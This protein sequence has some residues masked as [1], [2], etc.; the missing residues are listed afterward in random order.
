MTGDSQNHGIAIVAVSE[1]EAGEQTRLLS[2]YAARVYADAFPD[3]DLRENPVEWQ[4]LLSGEVAAPM[5]WTEVL[6]LLDGD[7]VAGGATVELYRGA[8]CGLLTYIAIHPDYRGRGLARRLVDR[9]HAVV[10]RRGGAGTPLFAETEHYDEAHDDAERAEIV[11]RQ[12][13]LAALGALA[14]EFD[15][16]MPPLREGAAPRRLHLLLLDPP[17]A[18]RRPHVPARTV[19]ALL[20]ELACSL[21]TT[22][23]T[24][25]PTRAMR[26]TLEAAS[27]L[28]QAPLP[29]TRFDARYRET[30]AFPS[31]AG[32][33][34]SFAFELG[35]A[36]ERGTTAPSAIVLR[37]IC[38]DLAQD[39]AVQEALVEPTRS[40]L[41]DVTT[42][43]PGHNGRPMLFLASAA[44]A[45]SPDRQVAMMRDSAWRYRY[46][47]ETRELATI[48]RRLDLRLHDSF[49]VFE[50]G[51]AFYI[52]SL[53]V[54]PASGQDLDEYAV[55]QLQSLAILPD[56]EDCARDSG[57]PVFAWTASDGED[58]TGSLFELA[59]ARVAALERISEDNP[60][61]DAIRDLLDRYHIRPP[62]HRRLRIDRA[63]LRNLCVSIE[64]EALVRA[65]ERANAVFGHD[66]DKKSTS[67]DSKPA[68]LDREAGM[69]PAH[70]DP[71]NAIDRSLLALAG[72]A[73]GVPDFPWQDN[74]EV[75]D[76]TQPAA[77]SVDSVL[78]V[79]PR[80][81]L[82][83][84]REW[85]SFE[86]S[87]GTL[88][89]CPYL[90]LMWLAS[91]HDE[92]TVET[93][94]RGIE[95]MVFEPG[96]GTSPYRAIPLADVDSVRRGA[97]RI[98]GSDGN[99]LL[100]R[101]LRRRLDLFRLSTIHRSGKLFRY[102]KETA[103]FAC[104]LEAK[105]TETRFDRTEATIDRIEGLVEDATTMK[106]AYAEKRTNQ[107]LAAIAFFGLVSIAGDLAGL[108]GNEEQ[109]RGITLLLLAAAVVAAA[110][111]FFRRDFRARPDD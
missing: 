69:P 82:E 110:V 59:E 33:S 30:P 5:P 7:A 9:A 58:F 78:Y 100:E 34:F 94:E 68:A 6:L 109:R 37:A 76:S 96:R 51:R 36:P 12:R 70:A 105:G 20:D 10:A 27:T 72:L 42:G 15:Y 32:A 99:R 39:R 103:A 31:I 4:R 84:A 80:F 71:G 24:H 56:D 16:V 49:C 104:L 90:L 108:F 14:I 11:D 29:A 74:S 98:L 102:P 2:Q 43:P 45:E 64:D 18:G 21:G 26:D 53:V 107:V 57:E 3:P 81:V 1:L 13:R 52:L 8:N 22:L 106:S 55:L 40:Y 67:H 61:P 83:V 60:C 41:D 19:L 66:G 93:I 86:S 73:T 65:A 17:A 79:H 38:T 46:E 44:A 77:T 50:S 47:N 75:H 62:G 63:S 48:H 92:L 88:G 35:F 23:D 85:R 111:Y 97:Q 25:P 54:P 95:A 87:L 91:L 28:A 101:N 89:N